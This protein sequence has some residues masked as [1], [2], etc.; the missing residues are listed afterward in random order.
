VDLSATL[1]ERYD[2]PARCYVADCR[3]LPFDDGSKDIVIVQGGL[4]HLP[5]LR[6]D[7]ERCLAEMS[8]I[9]R[10]DGLAVIV[11]PWRTPFLTFVH[12][13]SR[14][15]LA[16]R[17]SNKLDALAVMTEHEITTYE[18]WLSQPRMITEALD[19]Y[20]DAVKREHTWGKLRYV[21]RKR[22]SSVG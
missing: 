7:L 8:R 2:G 15:P 12:A 19:R 1:L 18:A 20:F 21:G 14:V 17:I 16:R 22:S 5:D 6:G 13:V 10:R 3:E 4:H 9:L 11:E